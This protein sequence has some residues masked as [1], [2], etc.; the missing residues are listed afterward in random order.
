MN[1]PKLLCALD[2]PGQIHF[3]RMSLDTTAAIAYSGAEMRTHSLSA[4][5]SS[6][7]DP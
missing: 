1:P 7:E 2:F 4:E 5:L 6:L 3:M